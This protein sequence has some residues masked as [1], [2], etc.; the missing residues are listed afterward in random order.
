MID[1]EKLVKVWGFRLI[2][3][4]VT[5]LYIYIYGYRAQRAD[6][7]WSREINLGI[8]VIGI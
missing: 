2:A 4:Q 3:F 8:I 1:E 6:L 5:M 7:D